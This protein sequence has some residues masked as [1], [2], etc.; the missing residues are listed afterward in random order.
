M[1]LG[2]LHHLTLHSKPGV[3]DLGHQSLLFFVFGLDLAVWDHLLFVE[4]G[5]GFGLQADDLVLLEGVEEE[6]AGQ[7]ETLAEVGLDNICG[8][9][10]VYFY[11]F[12]TLTRAR[13]IWYKDLAKF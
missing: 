4:F 11:A 7:I 5:L 12:L 3:G 6:P 13:R 2:L 8:T 1:N 10:W 9:S